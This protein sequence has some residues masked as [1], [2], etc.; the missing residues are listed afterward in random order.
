MSTI[1]LGEAMRTGHVAGG[2]GSPWARLDDFAAGSAI[3]FPRFDCHVVADRTDEV[4]GALRCVEL[5]SSLGHWAFGFISYEAAAGLDPALPAPTPESVQ[6]SRSTLPLVWFGIAQ[7]PPHRDPL[8]SNESGY[9]VGPWTDSWNRDEYD[10]AFAGVRHAIAAGRTY[11]C[12]LTTAIT[13][14]FAGEPLAFYSDLARA[15]ASRYCAYLDL[16]QHVIA[17]ASPEL[18]FEWTGDTLVTKPMKGTAQRGRTYSQDRSAVR[19]LLA[20]PKERAENII[21]V[22]LLRND[23]AKIATVG[24]VEV[25]ALLSPE[26]YPTVW[27]LT[28]EIAAELR[29]QVGLCEVLRAL[30]PCGS[31]TGAPKA[32]TMG[33]IAELEQ[34]RRGIY[35]GAIGWVAP[36]ANEVRARFSVAIRT[37]HVD[38]S[39]SVCEYGVGSGITWSSD[40]DAEYAELRAKRRIL[41]PPQIMSSPGN[42]HRTMNPKHGRHTA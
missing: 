7:T 36:A 34:R 29:P 1:R 20:S 16:G 42:A 5:A 11:Q 14:P 22:D 39:R 30:F 28:S 18:F 37:A 31:V 25:R 2:Q 15:Q 4:P 6:A 33:I 10:R 9:R 13:A 35:C 23:L 32:E 41:V 24:G 26:R 27:Q 19:G 12:N 38:R 3:T 17:S 8:I 40:P 21:I